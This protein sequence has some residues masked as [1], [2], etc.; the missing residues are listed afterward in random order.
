M[1]I[2]VRY[3]IVSILSL[4]VVKS[5]VT[6][7]FPFFEMGYKYKENYM[8]FFNYG[9]FGIGLYEI[10]C[11]KGIPKLVLDKDGLPIPVDFKDVSRSNKVVDTLF[12]ICT[13]IIPKG[14]NVPRIF[15]LSFVKNTLV[16]GKQYSEAYTLINKGVKSRYLQSVRGYS[17]PRE[18]TS[19]PPPNTLTY[20]DS[21]YNIH[22]WLLTEDGFKLDLIGTLI[23]NI[24]HNIS[25]FPGLNKMIDFLSDYPYGYPPDNRFDNGFIFLKEDSDVMY[26]NKEKFNLPVKIENIEGE[27]YAPAL[28]ICDNLRCRYVFDST[29]QIFKFTRDAY[30]FKSKLEYRRI[31]FELKINNNNILIEG[32]PTVFKTYTKNGCLMVPIKEFCSLLM[33][34]YHYRFIDRSVLIARFPLDEIEIDK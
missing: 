1:N 10:D 29:K 11:N 13:D 32:N 28:S 14:R 4:C 16:K 5:S 2:V 34:E 12:N 25:Y 23:P 3:I 15:T 21:D 30:V 6:P 8:P 17:G 31:D 7:Y 27:L 18:Q 22:Q 33:A 19:L 24:E 9:P 20:V 26:I